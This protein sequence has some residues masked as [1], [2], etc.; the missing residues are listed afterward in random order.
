MFHKMCKWVMCLDSHLIGLVAI[1][2]HNTKQFQIASL[3][4]APSVPLQQFKAFIARVLSHLS[5]VPTVILGDFNEDVM[6]KPDSSI[7]SFM[8][9]HGYSQLVSCATTDRGSLIDH[10]YFNQAVTDFVVKVSDTYYS[11]HDT[12]YFS[13]PLTCL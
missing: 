8:Y 4:R 7:V 11:D 10:V 13:L 3:Y 1:M 9:S 2:S 6:Y 5:N 12:V